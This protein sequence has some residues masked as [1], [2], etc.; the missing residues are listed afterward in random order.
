MDTRRERVGQVMDRTGQN[1]WL[2]PPGGGREWEA[3]AETLRL[4][5][6]EERRQSGVHPQNRRRVRVSWVGPAVVTEET[7]EAATP[8]LWGN[9]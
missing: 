4:A 8:N 7:E 3:R 6:P 5:T 1:V 9:P 2:R